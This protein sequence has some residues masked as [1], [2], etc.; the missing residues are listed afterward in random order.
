MVHNRASDRSKKQNVPPSASP[1]APRPDH[2]IMDPANFSRLIGRCGPDGPLVVPHRVSLPTAPNH[3]R[4]QKHPRVI[5]GRTSQCR[6]CFLR[7]GAGDYIMSRP[8]LLS[9]TAE[10]RP[11][12]AKHQGPDARRPEPSPKVNPP[13]HK[14]SSH[15]LR[16]S[17]PRHQDH[18]KAPVQKRKGSTATRSPPHPLLPRGLQSHFPGL[19]NQPTHRG[20]HL[21]AYTPDHPSL[22]SAICFSEGGRLVD[23]HASETTLQ[24]Q[25]V[26]NQEYEHVISLPLD[27]SSTIRGAGS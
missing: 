24:P 12:H 25:Q 13:T 6:G 7:T 9:H 14:I 21:H 22:A 26:A 15:T 27:Q 8:L 5:L 3:A 11:E 23:F 18:G 10:L 1:L 20:T 2:R 4:L 16:A 17:P 19:P